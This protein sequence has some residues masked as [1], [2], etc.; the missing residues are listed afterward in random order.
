[1]L[2][3]EGKNKAIQTTQG[4]LKEMGRCILGK[5]GRM[6]GRKVWELMARAGRMCGAGEGGNNFKEAHKLGK[7]AKGEE[8]DEEEASK[9]NSECVI[10]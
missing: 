1:M 4:V 7:L 2:S 8:T 6:S 9:P 10:C 3:Q 5:E